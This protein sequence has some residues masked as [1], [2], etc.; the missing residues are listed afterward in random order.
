LSVTASAKGAAAL[1]QPAHPEPP[2]T[3]AADT[4]TVSDCQHFD[5]G[6]Q[7]CTLLK[8]NSGEHNYN[9]NYNLQKRCPKSYS[10]KHPKKKG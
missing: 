6:R 4:Q 5:F 9:K 8:T 7:F 1:R 3:L 2:L 10:I